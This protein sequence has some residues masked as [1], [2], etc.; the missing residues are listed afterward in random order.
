[1]GTSTS[2]FIGKTEVSSAVPTSTTPSGQASLRR[3]STSPTFGPSTVTTG[4]RVSFS[5]D[6][7]KNGADTYLAAFLP[8]RLRLAAGC[9]FF[10]RRRCELFEDDLLVVEGRADKAWPPASMTCRNIL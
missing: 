9:G 6:A 5:G 4:M 7:T 1:M 8:R 2:C 10:L 3:A